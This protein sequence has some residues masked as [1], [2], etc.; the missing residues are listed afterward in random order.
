MASSLLSKLP[1]EEE[2]GQIRN[3]LGVSG[4]ATKKTDSLL[5]KLPSEEELKNVVPSVVVEDGVIVPPQP[6]YD[7]TEERL[8][9]TRTQEVE[10]TSLRNLEDD[11]EL[12]AD[13]L[14]YRKDRFGIE[15]DADA[16]ML[17]VGQGTALK[18]ATLGLVDVDTGYELTN[19][20]VVDDLMDHYRFLTQNSMNAGMEVAWLRSIQQKEAEAKAMADASTSISDQTEYTNKANDFAEQR[21]RALRLYQRAG[22]V[23]SPFS[24]KRREGMTAVEGVFDFIDAAGGNVLAVLTDP[25]TAVTAGLGRLVSGTL[26][27]AGATPL[28]SGI[29]AAATTAPIEAGGAAVVDTLVQKAEI[30]MGARTEIDYGRTAQV[31]GLAAVTA[32]AM[33][34]FGARNAAKRVSVGTRGQLDEAL[35]AMQ[36]KQVAEAKKTND[37][38]TNAKFAGDVRENLADGLVKI[39]GEKVIIR[40]KEGIIKAI[41]SE[42]IKESPNARSFFDKVDAVDNDFIDKQISFDMFER[43]TASMSDMVSGLKNG[44]MKLADNVSDNLTLKDLIGPLQKTAAGKERVS[45]RML[46]IMSNVNEESM[47]QVISI[48]GKYGVTKREVAA[49][50]FAD[51]SAAGR[52]LGNLSALNSKFIT[53]G[54]KRSASDIAEMAEAEAAGAVG[55]TWRRLE[56]IRRLTLVSGVAT[57]AR[58]TMGQTL[59][60]GVDTLV[61]GFES[62][63]NPR[64]KFSFK[65]TF[66][67]LNSTYLDYGDSAKIAQFMLDA[68][69]EQ[70][71]KFFNQY[72]DIS[73]K[74]AKGNPGQNALSKQSGG[75]TERR[76]ILDA[77]ENTIHTMNY[78]NRFQEAVYR[79]GAFTA[80]VQRQLY[81]RGVDI[82][83]VLKKGTLTQNVTEDIVTKATTDALEF[84]YA[85]QPKTNTGRMVNKFIV[86]TGLTTVIPFPRF[87]IKALENTWNYNVTGIGTALYKMGTAKAGGRQITDET[88]RQMSEGIAGGLPMIALGYSLRDRE[89]DL[90]GSE[91]YKLKDGMGNEID[92]R[93]FFP[94]T[95]YL[96]IGEM[97]HRGA[98]F[99][100]GLFNAFE[101]PEILKDT[102]KAE[103]LEGFTGTNFRGTNPAAL[104]VRDFMSGDTDPAEKM[105][106]FQTLGRYV[107]EMVSGYGQPIWQVADVASLFTDQNQRQKDYAD[108]PKKRDGVEAFFNGF[109]RPIDLRVGK[110]KQEFGEAFSFEVAE[111]PDR[112]DPRYEATPERVMPFM[113]LMFG[114]TL[115]RVPPDYLLKLYDL[116]FDYRSF[117]TR[118][119]SP[120]VDRYMNR[121]MGRAMNIEIPEVLATAREENGGKGLSAEETSARIGK[122]ISTAKTDIRAELKNADTDTILAA[123]V[124]K[125]RGQPIA[126]KRASLKAFQE[127]NNREPDMFDAAD[128]NRL[129]ELMQ[130]HGAYSD[131]RQ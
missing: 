120:K 122:W 92:M 85:A 11:D 39:Y 58:N 29:I 37:T 100:T 31:A 55:N 25:M 96:L 66:A 17:G 38:P 51:A 54:S 26:T 95:P 14:K 127:E 18:Y 106:L 86:D 21:E 114:A 5:N 35:Q 101:D 97:M 90:A 118:T 130:T 98:D 45:E 49:A 69:P 84:T 53:V 81:D 93:P 79:N 78:F 116:G 89:N 83:D 103:L 87:M 99:G 111:Y 110:I 15:L 74:L 33:S 59:R 108:D 19:E 107:G 46:N 43:V 82:V 80:S 129:T 73:A 68:F 72:A 27:A 2:L 131:Q 109:M 62:A 56:D 102:T 6:E 8:T 23:A 63:I 117:M 125:Y 1:S 40:N 76:P 41:D 71:M 30:E 34:G 3:N 48:M 61:Y 121:E 67:Q 64:K 28:K 36:K 65:G 10:P 124:S 60:S 44:S 42:V 57:A 9:E 16:D 24:S 7:S 47:D 20:S 126:S 123:M 88:W 52:T 128:V 12:V 112:E 4:D 94:L 70:K 22:N 32:G 75:V 77:W 13:I 91:W 50:M 113:K 105:D 115:D 104:I 119:S